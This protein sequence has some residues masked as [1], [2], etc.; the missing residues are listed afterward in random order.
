MTRTKWKRATQ[1]ALTATL[2]AGG[3]H[4]HAAPPPRSPGA[5]GARVTKPADDSGIEY[6]LPKGWFGGSANV[7]AYESGV[8]RAVV[9]GGK[10]AAFVRMV[11]AGAGDFGT[12]AQIIQAE[13]YRGR[14]L[15]LAAYLKAEG[16]GEGAGLWMRVD[17]RDAILAF[18]NMDPR[19]V[20]GTKDWQRVEVVLDVAEKAQVITFGLLLIGNGKVWA[21]DFRLEAVGKEV[22]STNLFHGEQAA[23][24]GGAAGA[25]QPSN[26]DFEEGIAA[27][28]APAAGG[29]APAAVAPLTPGQVKWLR[30]GAIAFDTAEPGRGFAD[31]QPLKKVIGDARIVALGEA[32]HGTSE[33]FKMKHRLTEFL[34]SELG[35]TLFAIEA[36]MPEAGRVNEFVLTGRGDPK[37]LLSGLYFW[38]WDTQEVLDMILW[39]RR[40]NES[41]R[42]RVQFLGFDMQFGQVAMAK[43]RAFVAKVDP[44]YAPDLEKAYEGLADYWGTPDRARAARA[45]PAAEKAARAKRARGALEHLESARAAYLKKAGAEEVDR[46]IQDA[47]VAAQAAE[48]AAGVGGADRDRCMAVNVAWILDH[49]PKGSRIVLWAHNGHVARQPGWMGSHL[50][51]RYGREL[52]VLGFACHEGRYTAV[53]RRRGLVDDNELKPSAPGSLEWRLHETRLPR[54]VLDLRRASDADPESSWLRRAHDFRSI[55]A[56]AMDQQFYPAVVPDLYDALIYFEQTKAS[57]CF[58]AKGAAKR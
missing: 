34:V 17:G 11:G 16:A 23:E 46:A 8:D 1:G 54:L 47:R 44:G 20:R 12:L 7:R 57:A 3:W 14:R 43:T 10:L 18:D 50:A 41:G 9:H 22:A 51:K 40:C 35:F 30:A 21:D 37:K 42:G 45:L 39:M 36:N 29:V 56:L 5:A 13:P 52:V 6:G 26:L 24:V 48:L 33:F 15:R 27:A 53:D 31:L 49:A 25:A 55:G 4:A 2:L 19:R 32:T 38:T 28:G 58:R